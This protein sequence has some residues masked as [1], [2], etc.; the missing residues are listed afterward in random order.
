MRENHT[1]PIIGAVR[2]V[3]LLGGGS[4]AVGQGVSISVGRVIS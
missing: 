2:G 4:V 1:G 3:H